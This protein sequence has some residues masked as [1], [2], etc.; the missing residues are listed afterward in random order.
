MGWAYGVVA[1]REVGY[2]VEAEC[3]REGCHEQIN[4]GLGFLC[5]RMH[6]QDDDTGCGGY[7]CG[8]HLFYGGPN[9]MCETCIDAW[10][11]VEA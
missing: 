4:H 10:S 6:G 1:G 7:F 3:D 9:A 2:S 11:G 8:R 5:G